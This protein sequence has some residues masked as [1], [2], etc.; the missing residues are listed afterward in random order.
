MTQSSLN[1]LLQSQGSFFI[2]LELDLFNPDLIILNFNLCT[3]FFK[4]MIFVK[5]EMYIYI[6]FSLVDSFSQFIKITL[7][8]F[9]FKSEVNTYLDFSFY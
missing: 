2:D 7:Q 8:F 1:F 3:Q 9:V 5:F 4:D 6:F